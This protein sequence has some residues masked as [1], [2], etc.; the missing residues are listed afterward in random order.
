[1]LLVRQGSAQNPPGAHTCKAVQPAL[2][3]HCLR[4]KKL[5]VFSC[6]SQTSPS[7]KH[8]A[9]SPVGQHSA[10][11]PP[12]MFGAEQLLHCPRFPLHLKPALHMPTP[13]LPQLPP[14]SPTAAH[15]ALPLT[16]VQ[17]VLGGQQM[18]CAIVAPGQNRGFVASHAEAPTAAALEAIS[19][20][21]VH[22]VATAA[23]PPAMTRRRETCPAR[24]TCASP[25]RCAVRLAKP[26]N[27]P[28]IS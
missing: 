14:G 11:S 17:V 25:A 12:Q 16:T 8:C 5:P 23:E 3:V 10:P 1:V 15:P 2:L 26:S 6:S 9:V 27:Q 13:W 19:I 4:Q 24:E 7:P 20:G 28:V 22:A 21:A 18:L